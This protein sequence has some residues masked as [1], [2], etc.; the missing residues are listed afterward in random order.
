M[1]EKNQKLQYAQLDASCI[2]G[3]PVARKN[4]ALCQKWV[5]EPQSTGFHF[6]KEDSF[7]D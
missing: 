3:L 6:A 2:V 1:R 5:E 4:F 7:R